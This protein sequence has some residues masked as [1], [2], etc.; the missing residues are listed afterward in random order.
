VATEWMGAP[1]RPIISF[2]IIFSILRHEM[3]SLYNFRSHG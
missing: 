1:T 2:A 3:L